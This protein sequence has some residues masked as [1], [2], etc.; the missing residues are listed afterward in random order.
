MP[1]GITITSVIEKNKISSSV[2][3]LVL[4]EIDVID[5]LTKTFIETLK[6]ANNTTDVILKGVTYLAYPFSID[7]KERE[8]E[9]SEIQLA[10]DDVASLVQGRMQAYGGGVGFNVRILI[11]NSAELNSDPDIIEEFLVVSSSAN[12]YKVSF[13]L[14][15]ENPLTISF[16][17][18]KYYRNEGFP[19][20]NTSSIR[21]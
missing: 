16:P 13:T 7:I 4:I 8:G 5:Q 6:M 12:D 18:R 19:A 15:I 9:L 14:G 10:I 17:K 1:K 21:Y 3:F 11:V 20:I 2:A